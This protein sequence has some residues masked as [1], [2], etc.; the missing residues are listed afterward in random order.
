VDW[1]AGTKASGAEEFVL[2]YTKSVSWD[3]IEG[4]DW[5]TAEMIEV[6][7]MYAS[8]IRAELVTLERVQ[9]ECEKYRAPKRTVAC[10]ACPLD[11]C[12][13]NRLDARRW[14]IPA[15]SKALEG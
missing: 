1:I 14:D 12:C 2:E 7:E 5:T 13:P 8:R 11:K 10:A 15:I 6:M 9:A 4:L 3:E